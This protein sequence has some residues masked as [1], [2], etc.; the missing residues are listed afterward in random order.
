MSKT[1]LIANLV[2]G[3]IIMMVMIGVLGGT[4]LEPSYSPILYPVITVLCSWNL[5]IIGAFLL[6]PRHILSG[7]FNQTFL[8]NP[9]KTIIASLN[10]TRFIMGVA[11]ILLGL[12]VL[13]LRFQE[14]L[15]VLFKK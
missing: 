11:W 15:S 14:F 1:K 12:L 2:L 13:C 3:V 5:I 6:L 10:W 8:K 4:L 9:M 7:F